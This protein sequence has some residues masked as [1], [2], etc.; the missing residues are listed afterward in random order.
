MTRFARRTVTKLALG[1][2][3]MT[4]ALGGPLLAGGAHAQLST[5]R[6][7]PIV[8]LSNGVSITM[9]ATM[10]TDISNVKSVTYVLHVPAGVTLKSVS[11]D[12]NGSLEHLSLVAD[13]TGTHYADQT[14]VTLTSGSVSMTAYATRQD[15]TVASKNGTT[16]TTIGLNWCT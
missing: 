16:G 10:Q 12:T 11:Y 6:T 9:W 13:Q 4:G 1:L 15:S 7:D 3:L 8:T 5:C 2:V 14:S